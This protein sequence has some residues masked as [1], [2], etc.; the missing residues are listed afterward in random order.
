MKEFNSIFKKEIEDFIS[1][2]RAKGYKYKSEESHLKRIDDF[3]C[4]ENLQTKSLDKQLVNKWN[5]K[6]DWESIANRNSR[7]SILRVF[8][9]YLSDLNYSVYVTPKNLYRSGP[10][11]QAHIYS[12]FELRSFFK[13]VDESQSVESECPYRGIIM[14]VFFRILYTSGLRVSEL[15]LLKLKD[16]HEDEEYITIIDGKNHKD[17]NVPIHPDLAIRCKEIKNTIHKY[18]NEDEYFF[19]IRDGQ[20][21]SINNVYDN[22][23]RYL[24]KAG[25]S[26]TGK[27][28][29]VHD[30]R[31]TYCVNLLRH[32]FIED[33]DLLNYLPYMK[34]IL[35]HETFNETA[36]YLKLTKELFP[37]ITLKIETVYSKFIELGEINY[38]EYY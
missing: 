31:H 29:R 24:E 35:G 2:K 33:K 3:F 11:Y 34:T 26:H 37:E 6:R 30:F 10:K 4:K 22:F 12:D 15:R 7:V 8:C 32:W 36:Y 1:L 13:A 28:P 38:D 16:M 27:G 14:P 25:I 19:K 20:C 21:M 23:R 5:A 18:S 17:R 9:E